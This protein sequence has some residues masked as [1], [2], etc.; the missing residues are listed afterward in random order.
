MRG[1][2]ALCQAFRGARLIDT[3]N[4]VFHQP[5]IARQVQRNECLNTGITDVLKLFVIRAIHVSFVGAKT[6]RSPAYVPNFFQSRIIAFKMRAAGEGISREFSPKVF[7]NQ[8]GCG[9]SRLD[10]QVTI[11]APPERAKDAI[12]AAIRQELIGITLDVFAFNHIAIALLEMRI[13]KDFSISKRNHRSLTAAHHE[14]RISRGFMGLIQKHRHLG[15]GRNS[16]G[17]MPLKKRIGRTE[18]CRAFVAP[19]VDQSQRLFLHQRDIAR[20]QHPPGWGVLNSTRTAGCKLMCSFPSGIVIVDSLPPPGIERPFDSFARSNHR[21]GMARLAADRNHLEST[22]AQNLPGII[23]IHCFSPR[24]ASLEDETRLP[25]H[26]SHWCLF[27]KIPDH[28]CQDIFPRMKVSSDIQCLEAPMEK[29]ALCRPEKH[30]GSV[31]KQLVPIIRAYMD[32]KLRGRS[33]FDESLAEKINPKL[34]L[35]RVWAGDPIGAPEMMK[36]ILGGVY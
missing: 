34:P 33:G 9:G 12:R 35:R 13:K 5:I 21:I 29:V 1:I 16:D 32:Y 18:S 2:S 36:Q 8:W 25:G 11:S 19:D 20:N 7:Q 3:F 24:P 27:S 26:L 28:R 14:L 23:R 10:S 30:P 15:M 6:S 4:S 17:S 31:Y 22:A